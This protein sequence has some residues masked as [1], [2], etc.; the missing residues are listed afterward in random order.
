MTASAAIQNSTRKI[1]GDAG[2]SFPSKTYT[3]GEEKA[4]VV[5]SMLQQGD[6]RDTKSSREIGMARTGGVASGR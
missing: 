4:Q 2:L 3:R 5:F 1:Y 6:G